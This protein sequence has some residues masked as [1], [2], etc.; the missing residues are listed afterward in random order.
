MNCKKCLKISLIGALIRNEFTC[1]SC[2]N[3][4]SL[5]GKWD[6]RFIRLANYI[7]NWSKDP[8]TKVGAVITDSKNRIIGTGYNG[9]PRGVYD[10]PERYDDK[11]TKH[12]MVVHAELNAI[13]NAVKSVSGCT[14]Y[15]SPLFTCGECAKAIIQSGIKK[16]VAYKNRYEPDSHAAKMY[17]EASIEVI[18]I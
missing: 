17:E 10:Q 13:L 11:D 14:I 8:S 2:M 18:L 7:S 16:V 1:E 4:N 9:F 5:C 12:G 15:V 3:L 6:M